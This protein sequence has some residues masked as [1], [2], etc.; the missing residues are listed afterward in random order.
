MKYPRA[1]LIPLILLVYLA[2]M[3]VLGYRGLQTGQTT[4]VQYILTIVATLVVIFL[5]HRFILRREKAREKEKNESN[6]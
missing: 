2:V 6:K 3:S 5:L 4:L 1:T